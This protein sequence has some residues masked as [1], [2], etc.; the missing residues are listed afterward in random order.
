MPIQNDRWNRAQA[1]K[2]RMAEPVSANQVHGGI[3][4]S[5]D[6]FNHFSL[7]TSDDFKLLANVKIAVSAFADCLCVSGQADSAV[8]SSDRYACAR[9]A[10]K[11]SFPRD[12]FTI[13]VGKSTCVRC[14]HTSE[15]N[16]VRAGV[17]GVCNPRK[18]RYHTSTGQGLCQ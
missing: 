5:R 8:E 16:A 7:R 12:V 13:C 1:V 18:L 2:I 9:S 3:I 15:R 4:L 6:S 11:F 10:E 17:G 14:G